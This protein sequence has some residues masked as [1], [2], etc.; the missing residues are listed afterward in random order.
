MQAGKISSTRTT[1]TRAAAPLR[2][3]WC[4]LTLIARPE[5]DSRRPGSRSSPACYEGTA[6]RWTAPRPRRADHAS[7]QDQQYQDDT[8]QGRCPPALVMVLVDPD[9][10]SGERQPT[11]WFEVITSVLRRHGDALDRTQTAAG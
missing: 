2:S 6:T 7:R 4:W 9:R 8:N 5:S 1:P 3:S 11:P 10:A